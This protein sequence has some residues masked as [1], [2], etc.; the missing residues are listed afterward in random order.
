[1]TATNFSLGTRSPNKIQLAKKFLTEQL[2]L[3]LLSSCNA[4][5]SFER[6]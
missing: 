4:A 3:K 1:M 6:D 5:V 2:C